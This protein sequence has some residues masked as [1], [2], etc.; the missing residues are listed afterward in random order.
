[1]RASRAVKAAATVGAAA[2][3]RKMRTPVRQNS[4][5]RRAWEL[6][7]LRSLRELE[8]LAAGTDSAVPPESE[9]LRR[10]TLRPRAASRPAAILGTYP[11]AIDAAPRPWAAESPSA[12]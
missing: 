9:T 6:N 7:L 4:P 12:A 1:M 2:V 8:E 3:Y 5:F 11:S 10:M